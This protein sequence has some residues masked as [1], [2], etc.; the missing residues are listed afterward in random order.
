MAAHY[1][2]R[3]INDVIDT[4]SDPTWL[5]AHFTIRDDDGEPLLEVFVERNY[6]AC[7]LPH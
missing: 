1:F 3:A 6:D 4:Q 7:G 5:D 2:T